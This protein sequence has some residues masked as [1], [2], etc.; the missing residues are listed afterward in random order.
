VSAPGPAPALE[1]RLSIEVGDGDRAFAVEAELALDAGILVLFGPSGVGKTL[2]LEALAGLVE[3]VRGRVH[4]RGEALLDSARGLALP[5]H[6]RRVGYVPQQHALFPFLDVAGNVAFG[7]PR[8]QRRRAGAGVAALLEELGL[9]ALAAAKPASLSGGERQ[10]VA[11]ARALAIEPRLLLL[12]EPFAS[13]DH[14]G[15]AALQK[16]LRA[17]IERRGVPAVLVTHDAEEAIALG[18]RLVRFERGKTAEAGDPRALVG[19][20]RVEVRGRVAGE[21]EALAGGRARARLAEAVVEGPAEVVR[22]EG[23]ELTLKLRP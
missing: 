15:R 21:V 1:A 11:L 7:L 9:G 20:A 12:D 2:T 6:A 8:A 10:R 16:L 22:G 5:A 23:G 4:V 18:D 17:V 3:R 14:A 19:G 13:I